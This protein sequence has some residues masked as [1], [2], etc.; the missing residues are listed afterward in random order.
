VV[1][2]V[3][4]CDIGGTVYSVPTTSYFNGLETVPFFRLSLVRETYKEYKGVNTEHR[5]LKA[6]VLP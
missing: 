1:F 3:Y 4:K 6:K 2:I 5:G